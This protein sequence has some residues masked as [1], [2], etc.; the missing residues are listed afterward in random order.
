MEQSSHQVLRLFMRKE[1]RH[2][3]QWFVQAEGTPGKWHS[4]SN[5][6]RP[7]SSHSS[8]A[9]LAARNITCVGLPTRATRYV[10]SVGLAGGIRQQVSCVA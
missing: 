1:S 2:V 10:A 8:L 4:T 7:E 5:Q 9:S 6:H 3:E